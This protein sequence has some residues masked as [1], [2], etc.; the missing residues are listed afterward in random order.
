MIDTRRN[1]NNM[2]KRN[3]L[4]QEYALAKEL[5]VQAT[6]K[7]ARVKNPYMLLKGNKCLVWLAG[8]LLALVTT[9]DYFGSRAYRSRLKSSNGNR[10]DASLTSVEINENGIGV[11]T[12]IYYR[13]VY[14]ETIKRLAQDFNKAETEIFLDHIN[15]I[16]GDCRKENLRPA[17]ASQNVMNRSEEKIEHA[18][19]TIEDY[20]AKIASGEW[21]PEEEV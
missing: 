10:P 11:H 2:S 7:N 12:E 13:L 21:E 18:F 6:S 4:T 15:H 20:H 19:F 5:G 9:S 17:D 1:T 16:R 3:S 14:R 8:K